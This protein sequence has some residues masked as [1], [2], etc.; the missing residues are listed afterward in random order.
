MNEA[1]LEDLEGR[2]ERVLK[3]RNMN[4]YCNEFLL[5]S[6]I[7][8]RD[9]VQI[10]TARAELIVRCF[11]IFQTTKALALTLTHGVSQH[12]LAKS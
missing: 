10:N 3:V 9:H 8:L 7:R 11:P 5:I 6:I 2:L 1:S 12:F 4:M